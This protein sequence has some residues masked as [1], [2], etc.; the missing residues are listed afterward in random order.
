MGAAELRALLR[1]QPFVPLR[2]HLTDGKQYDIRHPEMALLTRTTVDLGF[3][4]EPGS[5]IADAIEF[6]S[7]VHIVRVELLDGKTASPAVN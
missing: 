6:V 3:D 4:Q 7:L 5:G 2:L 1:R